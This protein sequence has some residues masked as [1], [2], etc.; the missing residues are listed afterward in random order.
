[1]LAKVLASRTFVT[2]R[3]PAL[4]H[5]KAIRV[6]TRVASNGNIMQHLWMSIKRRV[7]KANSLLA[8]SET[9][10]V[11]S[12][13]DRSKHWCRSTGSTDELGN[14]VVEDDDVVA[15]GADIWVATTTDVVDAACSDALW[16]VVHAGGVVGLVGWSV[17]GQV[18]VDWAA[19]VGWLCVW[20][21]V[22]DCLQR[23]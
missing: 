2:Y 14:A 22:S 19:L 1:M 21:W 11:D 4:R 23:S 16:W 7:D 17:L 8:S 9:L 13:E 15:D 12:V 5:S 10:L 20:Q 6:A 3:I 18:G